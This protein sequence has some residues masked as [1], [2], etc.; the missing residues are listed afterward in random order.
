M[1]AYDDPQLF[2]LQGLFEKI[3]NSKQVIV[4]Q[5]MIVLGGESQ[6]GHSNG[7]SPNPA[8][9]LFSQLM[10]LL[11]SD[12][13]EKIIDQPLE[14]TPAAPPPVSEPWNSEPMK[15]QE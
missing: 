15:P 3:A 11:L 13:A 10:T 4:P 5:R 9:N 6:N 12:R 14:P 2:A 8:T 7:S 1:R